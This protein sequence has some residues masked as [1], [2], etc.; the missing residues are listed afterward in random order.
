M[1][2]TRSRPKLVVSADGHGVVNHAGSRLLADLADATSLTSAFSEALHRLRPRGTG[3]DPGRVAVDLAVMLADGGEAIAD[4]AVLR[5]QRDVFGPVASTPTA[6]RVLAGIDTAALNALRA[7]R[8]QAREIAWLQADETGHPI[9]TSHAGGHEIPGLVLDIDATL[10]TCHSEKE[11]S[12]ATYKRGFGYHPMLCFLDNTGE[13]LAGILRPGN[14]GANTAADHITV[15]DQALAQ[16]PDVHRHGTKILVRADSAGGTRAFLAHLRALRQRGIQTTFSVGHAVT[17]QVRKAIRVLPDQ[18]WHPALEQ[19]GTLRDGAEVAEL[20]GLVDLTGYP[21]GTRIIVRRERPHPG[22]QLSLFD[23]D[24]GMRHHVFLTDTP[25]ADGGSLQDLEVRHRAHARAE[26]CIRCGKTTGFGRFPSRRFAINQAWLE[27]SLTAIDLLVWARTL[28]LDSELAT[29][30]P[31]KLRYRLLHTA[32]RITRGAR[33]LRLRIAAT[34][35]WRHE[36]TAAFSR[37]VA[38]P[39]PAT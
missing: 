5:D 27:L 9:P 36:L 26:D 22:A 16:I 17:E 34:W 12:A 2:T 13:A 25:V 28:P 7:A 32:A 11:E 24:E 23:Q 21:D 8:A 33:R 15:L 38:L 39:R 4:L 18:V 6:W 1:N 20:T 35:P 10:V 31:K 30:E 37:L 19:D 14:T 29:A 3:H